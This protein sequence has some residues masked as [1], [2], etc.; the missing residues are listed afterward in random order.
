MHYP[1]IYTYQNVITFDFWI[2]IRFLYFALCL[3]RGKQTSRLYDIV[4]RLINL[5]PLSLTHE[6]IFSELF[7]HCPKFF[8]SVLII[9][10]LISE[11]RAPF[12]KEFIQRQ[13]GFWASKWVF[14]DKNLVNGFQRQDSR[15]I[16]IDA[17]KFWNNYNFSATIWLIFCRSTET[18]TICKPSKGWILNY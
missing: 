13:N 14:S 4:I 11:S 2:T 5:D 16:K 10:I 9:A 15:F 3:N 8:Y 18:I 1:T 7:S 6:N 12:H 17:E